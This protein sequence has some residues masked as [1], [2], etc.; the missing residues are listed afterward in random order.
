MNQPFFS[1]V[2]PT[3]N[4][5]ELLRDAISSV[6]LQNFDDYELII[7]DNFNDGRTKNVIDEF[8]DNPHINYIRTE[9]ELKIPDHWEFATKKTKGVYTLIL[10]DRSFLGQGALRDIH[11]TIM[12]SKNVP[13]VFWNWGNFDEKSKIL[14]GEKKEAGMK[15]LRS[16]DLIRDF[17]RTLNDRYLPRPHVGCYRFDIAQKIRQKIGRLY[18]PVC[19]D[20]TSSLLFLA[21]SNIV[22][23]IPRPLVFFQGATVS[24]GTQFQSNPWPYMRSLNMADPYQFVP[25]K[26]PIASNVIFN[27]LL[28]IRSLAGGNLKDINIDWVFYFAICYDE[29]MRKKSIPGVDKKILAELF[30]EWRKTLS[31]FDEKMQ[32]SVWRKIMWRYKNI[33]KA[34]LRSSFLGNFLVRIKRFL[35]RKPTSK[36]SNALAA[37]G[38]NDFTESESK[39]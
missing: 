1:I 15:I 17:S 18:L 26:V 23:Y 38:F 14:W 19:P 29:L 5:P 27:D 9:N 2:I 33:L 20:F 32:A 36:S 8:R 34:Y 4:R 37:G 30:E 7:S 12:G 6:L 22:I 10:T 3:K 24:S 16:S 28:K 21:Y 13:V 25:I 31:N 11:N 35:L 39:F